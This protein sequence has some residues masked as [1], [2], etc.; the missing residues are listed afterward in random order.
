[1]SVLDSKIDLWGL[2]QRCPEK[3]KEIKL[4]HIF[5]TLFLGVKYVNKISRK[6]VHKS[7]S[8]FN[9]THKIFSFYYQKDSFVDFSQFIDLKGGS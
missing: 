1:M 3:K 9:G 5:V 6:D 4:A 2:C 7:W 8:C